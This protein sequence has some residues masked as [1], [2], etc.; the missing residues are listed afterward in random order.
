MLIPPEHPVESIAL[1]AS[2][3]GAV[4]ELQNKEFCLARRGP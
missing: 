1:K 2:A 4:E 3:K